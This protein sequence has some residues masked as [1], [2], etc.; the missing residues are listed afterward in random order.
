[1]LK[2]E[3]F[4]ENLQHNKVIHKPP[5]PADMLPFHLTQKYLSEQNSEE[6]KV[7]SGGCDF[8][9]SELAAQPYVR[10][11]FKNHFYQYGSVKTQ[12]T[13]KGNKD[14]DVFHP[15]YRVKRINDEPVSSF[16]PKHRKDNKNQPREDDLFLD[17][18]QNERLGLITLSINLEKRHVDK[19]YSTIE[20][21]YLPVEDSPQWNIMRKEVLRRMIDKILL[22]DIVKEVKTELQEISENYVIKK[23]Q[24]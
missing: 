16:H 18:I 20:P 14:L 8:A 10:S 11:I 9:A 22:P 13:E 1:M 6:M 7:L 2:P 23:C 19:F 15:S 4:V 21:F 12:P 5:E 3:S 24:D 17:I